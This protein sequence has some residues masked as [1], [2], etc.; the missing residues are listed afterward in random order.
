VL[1]G[2]RGAQACG[3]GGAGVEAI[4]FGQRC[5]L[6]LDIVLKRKYGKLARF[7]GEGWRS[8]EDNMWGRGRGG[9]GSR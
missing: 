2:G 5:S 9:G 7:T 3:D 8:S 4:G 6:L 1:E